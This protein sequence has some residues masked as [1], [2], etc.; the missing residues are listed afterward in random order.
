MGRSQR[1]IPTPAQLQLRLRRHQLPPESLPSTLVPLP[2]WGLL[3]PPNRL[4]AEKE[5]AARSLSSRVGGCSCPD[6]RDSSVFNTYI[7]KGTMFKG[8]KKSR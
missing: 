6:T 7:K 2:P 4:L 3:Y 8:I 5:P 1:L